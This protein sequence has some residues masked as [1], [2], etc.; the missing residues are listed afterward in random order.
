MLRVTAELDV[1]IC[2]VPGEVQTCGGLQQPAAATGKCSRLPDS[3]ANCTQSDLLGEPLQLCVASEAAG[4]ARDTR[5]CEDCS[6]KA[7]ADVQICQHWWNNKG[8]SDV[9]SEWK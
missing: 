1:M 4:T 6:E 3:L 2:S 5:R 9:G 8:N 7:T